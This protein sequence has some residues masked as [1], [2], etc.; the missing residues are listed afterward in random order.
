L[1]NNAAHDDRHA[2]EDV[3]PEYLDERIAVNLKHQF[4]ASQA[5]LPGMRGAGGGSIVC[6]GST[7]W[8]MGLGGMAVYTAALARPAAPP[9]L[10]PKPIMH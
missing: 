2:T 5:V 6:T 8:M 9:A 3:T 4:F 1:I 7:S 10:G